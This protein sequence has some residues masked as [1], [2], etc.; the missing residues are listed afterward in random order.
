MRTTAIA[1]GSYINDDGYARPIST[2]PARAFEATAD[3]VADFMTPV[4]GKAFETLLAEVMKVNKWPSSERGRKMRP[5]DQAMLDFYEQIHVPFYPNIGLRN[6]ASVSPDSENDPYGQQRIKFNVGPF[7]GLFDFFHSLMTPVVS[8][9]HMYSAL[10]WPDMTHEEI[11][12][13]MEENPS[14]S[15]KR[16]EAA[17]QLY[18]WGRWQT[19]NPADQNTFRVR[20]IQFREI[21]RRKRALSAQRAAG[22]EKFME[23]TKYRRGMPRH[24]W[25]RWEMGYARG[26]D[27]Y[28]GG[29]DQYEDSF[30][31]QQGYLLMNGP[32]YGEI[33]QEF[34]DSE[35]G[36]E[37]LAV[38]SELKPGQY[39]EKEIEAYLQKLEAFGLQGI[40]PK[41]YWLN[42]EQDK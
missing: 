24:L 12:V 28:D 39:P 11:L 36:Q 25:D 18:Q 17:E 41:T 1:I 13:Y 16:L 38:F 7:G 15:M 21:K 37:L 23:P 40:Q 42:S 22:P 29:S 34:L 26:V 8:R 6:L 35:I 14:D 32:D 2:N 3:L 30:L 9:F 19:W 33:T 5:G 20:D 4:Y 27:S 10:I 31:I